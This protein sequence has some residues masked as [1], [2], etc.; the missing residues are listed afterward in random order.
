MLLTREARLTGR[1]P[2][3]TGEDTGAGARRAASLEREDQLWR[4]SHWRF[5]D[6]AVC[7]T[8]VFSPNEVSHGLLTRS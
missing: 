4:F 2:G 6:A 3:L 1:A 8:H 7:H 5:P